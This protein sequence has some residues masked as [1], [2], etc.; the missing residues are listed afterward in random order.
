MD[1]LVTKLLLI[2][3]GILTIV[4]VMLGAF[5]VYGFFTNGATYKT[6]EKNGVETQLVSTDHDTE[7]FFTM[8]PIITTVSNGKGGTTTTTSMMPMYSE[9][10]TLKVNYKFEGKTYKLTTSNFDVRKTSKNRS[11]KFKDL[12]ELKAHKDDTYVIVY[13]KDE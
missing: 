11:I 12:K 9:I 8:I 4:C 1:D 2:I 5:A 13:M 7:S 10:D 6:I 3:S